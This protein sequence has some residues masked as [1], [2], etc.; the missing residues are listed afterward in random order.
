MNEKQHS[1]L[2]VGGVVTQGSKVTITTE[3]STNSADECG[4]SGAGA[5]MG[6]KASLPFTLI[7][8]L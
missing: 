8:Y 1:V 5:E 6:K 7:A 2:G 3:R 4:E